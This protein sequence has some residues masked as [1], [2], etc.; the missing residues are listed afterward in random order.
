MSTRAILF[1]FGFVFTALV[2]VLFL[3]VLTQENPPSGGEPEIVEQD[4]REEVPASAES[5]GV[6]KEEVPVSVEQS[7]DSGTV[8]EEMPASAES[9]GVARQ[10]DDESGI[11]AVYLT[12]N[13]AGSENMINYVIDLASTTEINAVVLDVKDFSGKVAYHDFAIEQFHKAGVYV[14]G[15]I[16]VFQDPILANNR[17]ELAVHNKSF[18]ALLRKITPDVQPS[19]ATVWHDNKGLAWVDPASKEVWDYNIAVAKT[20]FERGYEEINFDYIRFPSDGNL[21]DMMFLSWDEKISKREIIK[22]F[23]VYLRKELMGSVISADLFGLATIKRDDIGIGQVIEDAFENFDYVSPM[24]YPSHYAN[25][26][27]GYENPA[28]YPYEIVKYSL[29]SALAR[30]ITNLRPWLQDFDLGAD[31]DTE[32]VQQQ[33]QAVKDA[34]GEDNQSYMLWSPTNIYTATAL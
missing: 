6:V 31:Y 24:V 21:Q 8:K 30:G 14:I 12:I 10:E 2:T 25:G 32:K 16:T 9:F 33:I 19:L 20:A 5:Y 17:P 11:R 22:T 7:T 23:F 13:S 18:L 27:L 1:A 26:F 15:R 34:L 29:D 4:F 28:E 3:F